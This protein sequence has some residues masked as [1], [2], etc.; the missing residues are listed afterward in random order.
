[1]LIKIHVSENITIKNL[2]ELKKDLIK[3][4]IHV[5][6]IYCSLNS[7]LINLHLSDSK[8]D[9]STIFKNYPQILKFK[10]IRYC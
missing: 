1:M 8:T 7:D 6:K 4:N 9:L 10:K 5:Y 3:N 2:R